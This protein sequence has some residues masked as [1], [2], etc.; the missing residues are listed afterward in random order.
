VEGPEERKGVD[1][2]EGWTVDLTEGETEMIA[3]G[4]LDEIIGVVGNFVANGRALG[5]RETVGLTLGLVVSFIVGDGAT[6]IDGF[7]VGILVEGPEE[8]KG[9]D[10]VEGWTVDLTEGETEMIAD[11]RLDEIV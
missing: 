2:V 10:N 8:R 5:K 3:D 6:E 9:V 4:R 7:E 1:N 11:G